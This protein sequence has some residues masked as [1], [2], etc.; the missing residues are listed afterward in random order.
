MGDFSGF[1]V[2]VMDGDFVVALQSYVYALHGFRLVG[3]MRDF[4]VG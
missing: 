4:E 2:E 1:G 3:L